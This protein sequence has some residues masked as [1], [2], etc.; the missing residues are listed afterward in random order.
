[1][2][3]SRTTA[4]SKALDVE[5]PFIDASL[6]SLIKDGTSRLQNI[7]ANLYQFF[8]FTGR[9]DEAIEL[10]QQA[11]QKALEMGDLNNAG[12]RAQQAAFF[13]S[14]RNQGTEVLALASRA[15]AYWKNSGRSEKSL[16]LRMRGLGYLLEKNY[17]A[18]IT[19]HKE[20]LKLRRSVNPESIDV[21]ISLDDLAE[22][23]LAQGNFSAAE[24]NCR[25]A[26]DIFK[27]NHYLEGVANETGNLAKLA[28]DQEQWQ[29]AEILARDGPC[30]R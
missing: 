26:L 24:Q 1:M 19:V 11:E 8:S 14:L 28:L 29:Q 17:R 3:A 22:V 2:E 27:K 30:R 4:A 6:P 18:A 9:W 16:A 25:E 10:N 13:Y 23:E 5:W 12:Q 20:A 15:E 7:C 21:A